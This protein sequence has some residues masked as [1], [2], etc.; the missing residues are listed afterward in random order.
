MTIHLNNNIK[1]KEIEEGLALFNLFTGETHFIYHPTSNIISFLNKQPFTR[2]E[3]LK[4]YFANPQNPISI[5][6]QNTEDFNQF[7][8]NAIDSGIIFIK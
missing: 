2:S 4:K 1:V 7:V 5:K 8:T 6:Q 3:L